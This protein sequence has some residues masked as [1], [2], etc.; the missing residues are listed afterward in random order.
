MAAVDFE[1]FRVVA[2]LGYSDGARGGQPLFDPVMMFKILVIRAMDN[3]SG[4]RRI[5]HQRP[6]ILRFLRLTLADRVPNVRTIWLF[7]EKLTKAGAIEPR[8]CSVWSA[9]AVITRG[10][11]TRRH[12][13]CVPP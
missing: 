9:D 13:F 8:N 2:A 5:P 7:R 4:E 10:G 12:Y 3:L 11:K 1:M 6:H